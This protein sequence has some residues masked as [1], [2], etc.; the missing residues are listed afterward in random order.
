MKQYYLDVAS[1][2][3]GLNDR[4][5]IMMERKD[6]VLGEQSYTGCLQSR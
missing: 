4:C 2:R 5:I 1:L 3:R 6:F